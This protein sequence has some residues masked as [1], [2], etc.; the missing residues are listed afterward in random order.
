[1]MSKETVAQ[2]RI[3]ASRNLLRAMGDCMRTI[4][5]YAGRDNEKVRAAQKRER[6]AIDKLNAA[7]EK[8]RNT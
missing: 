5:K 6:D 7:E 3:E 8:E 4:V 1:M 2:E